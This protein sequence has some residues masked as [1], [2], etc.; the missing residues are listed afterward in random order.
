MVH[1][2]IKK[3]SQ[4]PAIFVIIMVFLAPLTLIILLD[5]N[6]PAVEGEIQVTIHDVAEM[7]E[8]EALEEISYTHMSQEE[9]KESIDEMLDGENLNETAD[10]LYALFLIESRDSLADAYA[11]A[12]SDQ[13]LGYYDTETKEM[14]I[15]ET[16][17][18]ATMD[19][20]TLAHEFTH[21]LQ[22]Q[23]FDLGNFTQGET[24][25]ETMARE[26]VVEGDAT[27]L[28]MNYLF[29]LPAS[30][31][32]ELMYS[33]YATPTPTM[34][35][36]IEQMLTFPYLQGM[37]F[38]QQLYGNDGWASVDA[39]YSN[40]PVSTEQ[41]LHM[42]KYLA[43]EE[44]LEVMPVLEIPGMEMVLNE[45]LGEAM[46]SMMLGHHISTSEAQAAAAGWGGDRFYYFEND[47]GDDF[48]SAW[49]IEWDTRAECDEFINIFNTWVFELGDVDKAK[50][51]D[52]YANIIRDGQTTITIYHASDLSL[53]AYV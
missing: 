5:S 41:V 1:S 34:P 4:W 27:L 36:A 23:H 39:V 44:P 19:K 52:G 32:N 46:V 21:A 17:L 16:N 38:I 9:L 14:V 43:G 33:L 37:L 10:L 40:P 26:A 8:L 22:D 45:T 2:P 29:S 50:F 47:S 30:E 24:W 12:L 35:Y 42:D 20:I 3:K 11:E 49:T 28:M 18:S 31:Q 7:R 6:E 13:V 25:D 53:Y 15:V 51:Q 48:F